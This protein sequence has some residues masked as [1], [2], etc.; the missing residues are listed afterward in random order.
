MGHAISFGGL[1]FLDFDTEFIN[2]I[3]NLKFPGL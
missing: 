1:F 2:I 3:S